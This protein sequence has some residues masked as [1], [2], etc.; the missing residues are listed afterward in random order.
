M[1]DKLI[2]IVVAVLAVAALAAV[3]YR[4]QQDAPPPPTPDKPTVTNEPAFLPSTKTDAG[5]G[6]RPLVERSSGEEPAADAP[7]EDSTGDK[8]QKPTL[9]IN[10]ELFLPPT[11]TGP[12]RIDFPDDTGEK[13]EEAAE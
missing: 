7:T 13:T 4:A 9:T 8:Q 5:E 6:A 3:V 2:Q 11:K 1:K 10:R 12:I